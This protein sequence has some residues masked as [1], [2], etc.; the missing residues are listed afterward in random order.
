MTKQRN[1][2]L[3][4]ALLAATAITSAS[5]SAQSLNCYAG[6]GWYCGD[7]IGLDPQTVYHC[8]VNASG[9]YYVANS[10]RCEHSCEYG[11]PGENDYCV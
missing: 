11:D 4:A 1:L 8:E 10:Y 2:G 5:A 6:P 3:G 7:L 9:D